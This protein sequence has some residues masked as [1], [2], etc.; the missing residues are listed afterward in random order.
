MKPVDSSCKI[1]GTVLD[2]SGEGVRVCAVCKGR[3]HEE[4]WNHLGGCI[5][6]ECRKQLRAAD[7]D[8][9]TVAGQRREALARRRLG[10]IAGQ[11]IGAAPD[12]H[13]EEQK[14]RIAASLLGIAAALAYLNAYPN[15]AQVF[16]GCALLI[17]ALLWTHMRD[18][19][20]GRIH[21]WIPA[22]AA[23]SDG[24]RLADWLLELDR[25]GELGIPLSDFGKDFLPAAEDRRL[26]DDASK[27]TIL[28]V[29]AGRDGKVVTIGEVGERLVAEARSREPRFLE[30]T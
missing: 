3:S 27:L 5:E 12:F 21:R 11:E 10:W 8:A 1:C 28:K 29:D 20:A 26:F 2:P 25:A 24:L 13:P 4:C 17:A 16:G 15:L 9:T 7:R 19:S 18:R 14:H 23:P 30:A 6:P 22:E